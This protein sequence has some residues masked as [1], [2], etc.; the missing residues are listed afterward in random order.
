METQEGKFKNWKFKVDILRK[1]SEYY[2]VMMNMPN[3]KY[4]K[5]SKDLSS[6]DIDFLTT[7]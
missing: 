5:L 6:H 7:L 4:R 2:E 1:L 3:N